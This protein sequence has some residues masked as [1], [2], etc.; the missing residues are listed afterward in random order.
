MT[1]LGLRKYLD[2]NILIITLYHTGY[3]HN[4]CEARLTKL[5]QI[6]EYFRY[7]IRRQA[8][9]KKLILTIL[10]AIVSYS[11]SYAQLIEVV[12]GP[13]VN[14][15][16]GTIYAD[17]SETIDVDIWLRGEPN[18]QV[19]AFL[20]NLSTKNLYIPSDSRQEG[21]LNE[22][23]QYWDDVSFLDPAADNQNYGY[24][25]QGILGICSMTEF[26]D[27]LILPDYSWIW[28]GSFRMTTDSSLPADTVICDAFIDGFFPD[29]G[30]TIFADYVFGEID[31]Q[32]V[33]LEFPCLEFHQGCG[34]YVPGDFNGSGIFNIA[35]IAAEVRYLWFGI[36]EPYMTCECP[37]GSG[38][39]WPIVA[40]LNNSCT[41]NIA[42]IVAGFSKLKTGQPELV[43]CAECPP[44]GR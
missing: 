30:Y 41:F 21:D 37:R 25:V 31:P 11:L 28:V 32:D 29:L 44:E 9:V 17:T 10:I 33:S 16:A 39:I 43:P 14:G 19:V 26:C 38:H 18:V 6:Y 4:Y 1:A 2:I 8:K 40:D 15:H 24:T 34:D 13:L 3:Y 35:D 12:F 20:L 36:P 23:F 22:I 42:D 7:V 5:Y 27:S